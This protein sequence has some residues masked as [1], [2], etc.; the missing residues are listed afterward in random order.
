MV[1]LE[2]KPGAGANARVMAVIVI[3]VAISAT[4]IWLLTGGGTKLFSPHTTL[5]TFVPDAAGLGRRSEVRLSGIPIGNVSSITVSGS[6]DPQRIVRVDMNV[7]SRFLKNI[8]RDS[9]AGIRAD[10]LIGDQFVSIDEGTSPLPVTENGILRSEPIKQAA[11]RADLIRALHDELQQVDDIVTQAS[12]S[13]TQVGSLVLGS[14][15]YDQVLLRIDAFQKAMHAFV[16]PD[17]QL[18]PVL[19]SSTLYSQIHNSV[20]AIDKTLAAVQ[21]GEGAAGHLFASD[22]QYTDLLRQL[23]D[24]RKSL[25]DA[26]KGLGDDSGYREIQKML[27]DTDA[28]L[29]AINAGEGSTGRLLHDRQLYESLN[30]SLKGMRILLED[31]K[32]NP[33][34]YLRYQVR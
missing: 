29:A 18:G 2:I 28:A 3:A 22:Q 10:T 27:A 15:E 8:P 4:F 34:K 23:R 5:T 7:D 30:G 25:A 24:F 33:Q 21:R 32:L 20:A 9:Q 16:G 17:S 31:L 1:D 12:S 14:K 13:N 26:G 19:F 6:L 11:D